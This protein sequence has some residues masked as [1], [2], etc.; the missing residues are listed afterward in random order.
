MQITNEKLSHNY[1][2]RFDLCFH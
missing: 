2:S 1:N